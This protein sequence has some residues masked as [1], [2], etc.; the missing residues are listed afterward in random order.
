MK[1]STTSITIII[2]IAVLSL[3][4]GCSDDDKSTNP[5]PALISLVVSDSMDAG[6]WTVCWDQTNSSGEQV[7][8]GTYRA[9][10]TAGDFKK[11]EQFTISQDVQ[12]VAT[13]DCDTVF[14]NSGHQLPLEFSMD[15]TNSEYA[16]GATV[17]IVVG[18]GV[19]RLA[20]LKIMKP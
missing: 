2:L 10:I 15:V 8:P 11:S 13:V 18:I 19:R 3:S 5:G 7:A 6:Y 16:V 4:I 1:T 9:E 17:D 14:E 12:T 20:T